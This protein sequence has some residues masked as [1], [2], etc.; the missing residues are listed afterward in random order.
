MNILEQK[1][2]LL[3]HCYMGG[4]G[5]SG[6]GGGGLG[7]QSA[8]TRNALRSNEGYGST[9][10]GGGSAT[11]GG[12]RD[13]AAQ[14]REAAE[15]AAAE[16]ANRQAIADQASREQ[17][18][19]DA[20]K[21]ADAR[22]AAEQAAN[23]QAAR[24]QAEQASREQAAREAR[25]AQMAAEQASR[26][27]AARDAQAES[28][29]ASAAAEANRVA[30]EQ[31][32]ATASLSEAAVANPTLSFLTTAG[33]N[34]SEKQEAAL[35]D[36]KR[37]NDLRAARDA[38]LS[39]Y[40]G[41]DANKYATTADQDPN[42]RV[43][44]YD[45]L[46][47]DMTKQT[48]MLGGGKQNPDGREVS[49]DVPANSWAD[50]YG[51]PPT[52][53]EAKALQA[54]GL[55]NMTNVNP[56]NTFGTNISVQGVEGL[57]TNDPGQT[58]D[59]VVAATDFTNFVGPLARAAAM[60]IPGAS[61]AMTLNDMYTGKI[62][63]GDVASNVLLGMLAKNLGIP[64]GVVTSAINGNPGGMLSSAL[65]GQINSYAS[66]ELGTNPI[67][68][69]IL[70]KESGLYSEIGKATS[71]LN[72]NWGTTKAIS[73][74]F[75][76]GLRNLG[77]T[78]GT[79]APNA[80]TGESVNTGVSTQ[81]TLSNYLDSA[82]KGSSNAPAPTPA[83]TAPAPTAP[84]APAKAPKSGKTSS[85]SLDALGAAAFGLSGALGLG[86]S[87]SSGSTASTGST[88]NTASLSSV[89]P[90]SLASSFQTK[91]IPNQPKFE[92]VLDEFN[93]LQQSDDPNAVQYAL[94]D[95]APQGTDMNPYTYGVDRPIEDILSPEAVA[96]Q[97]EDY[98]PDGV[99]AYMK[100]GIQ[101]ASGGAMTGTRYGKYARGGLST[102][103]MASGGKM[104]VDF[105]HGDAVTGAG[106]GQSDDI[107]AMLADGE[108]VFPADV[109]AAIG[110][111]STKAGSDKLYDMMHGIRAHV[112]S[113]KPK[114]LPPEI[115]SPLDFLK[116]TKRQGAKHG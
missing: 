112:R 13:S 114:D 49:V 113:A 72:Q 88:G 15:S 83:P 9:D 21:A 5:S 27:Q 94:S 39:S 116:N 103:L 48:M 10:T 45:K 93:Q 115:K 96:M 62:T 35:A 23:D 50:V 8:E 78:A 66:K 92:S 19:R 30:A 91:V 101:A 1:R 70:G 34:P 18:A 32:K 3:G 95:Q 42:A 26:E 69:G 87:G 86:S 67:F 55:G 89:A 41:K 40:Y 6:S 4:G 100:T 43:A 110:N 59:S 74:A 63:A 75:N 65:V 97:G 82:S 98:S 54:I 108:F 11:V 51:R 22:M 73:N 38:E 102:P 28:D 25:D 7:A 71:G 90:L 76:E 33:F 16:A 14:A 52:Y 77:I 12:G 37:V 24:D 99:P 2:K 104:R 85:S 81:D 79:G 44:V 46:K 36:T 53:A 109:V 68:T 47:G 29:R 56:N 57:F 17:A 61:L 64:V 80:A 106:D 60:F 31:A 111:G 107:P 105:R 84:A 20:A 58:V